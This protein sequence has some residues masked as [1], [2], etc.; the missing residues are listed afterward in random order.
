MVRSFFISRLSYFYILVGVNPVS[1][2]ISFPLMRSYDSVHA[3]HAAIQDY[4]L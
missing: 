3:E 2:V 1:S 4:D